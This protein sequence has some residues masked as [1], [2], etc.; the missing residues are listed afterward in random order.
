MRNRSNGNVGLWVFRRCSTTLPGAPI[1]PPALP[2]SL[3]TV[4]TKIRQPVIRRFSA[5][6]PASTIRLLG[7]LRLRSTQQVAKI[8][9]PAIKRSLTIQPPATTPRPVLMR[10]AAPPPAAT[11]PPMAPLRSPATAPVPETRRRVGVPCKRTRTVVSMRLPETTHS[12]PTRPAGY[13]NVATGVDA[14]YHD[15][16]GHDNTASGL[17]GPF[18]QHRF[19]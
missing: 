3:P 1:R 12:F 4:A 7:W 6:Q 10:S 19:Q 9:L 2:P 15:Q 14:L 5:T 16:V 17:S 13:S 8:R 18:A 11:T